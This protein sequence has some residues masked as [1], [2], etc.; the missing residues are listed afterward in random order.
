HSER[1]VD[2]AIEECANQ[3][4]VA[5]AGRIDSKPT[6]DGRKAI[7]LD[8]QG[9]RRGILRS[10]RGEDLA[11][12][13]QDVAG[14]WIDAAIHVVADQA[15]ARRRVLAG[16]SPCGDDAAA[17]LDDDALRLVIAVEEV[18]RDRPT[19]AKGGIN[20]S[21]VIEAREGKVAVAVGGGGEAGDD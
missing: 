17:G 8:D 11:A 2:R 5:V 16:G 19:V 12:A 18:G 21:V 1:G 20:R 7:G 13:G 9:Q 6:R 15:E 4:K 14:T 3:G 10:Y